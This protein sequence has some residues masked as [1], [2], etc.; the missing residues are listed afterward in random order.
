MTFNE[1]SRFGEINISVRNLTQ[2]RQRKVA[3]DLKI[4]C[5]NGFPEKVT[6]KQRGILK[7]YKDGKQIKR[8]FC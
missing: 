5:Q 8:M 2:G 7:K 1:E 4:L 3:R 6:Q